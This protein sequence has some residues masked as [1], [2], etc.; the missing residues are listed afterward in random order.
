MS[1][2]NVFGFG[3][4][5]RKIK[6]QRLRKAIFLSVILLIIFITWFKQDELSGPG[7]KRLPSSSLLDS[8]VSFSAG[9]TDNEADDTENTA[10]EQEQDPIKERKTNYRS[11]SKISPFHSALRQ[12]E[13]EIKNKSD[14]LFFLKWFDTVEPEVVMESWV[15]SNQ[16]E[17]CKLLIQGFYDVPDWSNSAIL[18]NYQNDGLGILVFQLMVE[19][20]RIYDHCFLHGKEDLLTILKDKFFVKKGITA[21]DFNTRMFP[22]INFKTSKLLWPVVYDLSQS[23]GIQDTILSA[24]HVGDI[25]EFNANFWKNWAEQSVGK[26]IIVTMTEA[27]SDM[28][29][30]QLKVFKA[31]GNK[32]PIQ[33]I[34]TGEEATQEFTL[35]L[36][37]YSKELGQD[38]YLV[39]VSSMMD[40][41]FVEENIKNFYH[42]WI[43][44]LFNTFEEAIFIDID[45]VPY[46]P[47]KK[48]FEIESYKKTGI[49]MYRDRS[50][51]DENTF[52]RCTDLVQD[53]EP[54]Q[55]ERTM[56]DKK[57]MFDSHW[58]EMNR[59]LKD[60]MLPSTEALV[61]RNFFEKLELH[62]VDSGLIVINKKQKLN[63]LLMSLY[64][65]LDARLRTCIYGDKEV[66]WL[67]ELIAGETYSIDPMEGGILGPIH[68]EIDGDKSK[69]SI[70]GSQI[71]HVDKNKQLMWSNG[72]LRTC[73]FYNTAVDDFESDEEYFTSRYKKSSNLQRIYDSPLVIEGVII[74]DPSHDSWMQIKECSRYMYCAFATRDQ[75]ENKNNIG[76]L[77][78]FGK[79]QQTIFR[80]LSELWNSNDI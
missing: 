10:L 65:N 54:S 63:G 2:M 49:L 50:L 15:Q 14:K 17:Q 30:R 20:M 11:A 47:M 44:Q 26:G 32:L 60:E 24:P 34:T 36:S 23:N 19:R 79:Q 27:D 75:T 58:S 25:K 66:V 74:P 62:H 72:G 80:S 41:K 56:I 43:A 69:F 45:A 16:T 67:G 38:V 51:I 73:K 13:K 29:Y 57:M 3:S 33:V 28:F 21:Q 70:C 68:G 35:K 7:V 8:S 37:K 40:T 12:I 6:R 31:L 53:V 9:N 1:L 5:S 61:Y 4:V 78:E 77:I 76:K 55:E 39:D 42:K 46:I 18:K 64:S 59:K 48:Y 52:R 22:Y 71:A